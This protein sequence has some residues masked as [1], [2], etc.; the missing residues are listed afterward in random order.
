MNPA[1]TT[2]LTEM[3]RLYGVHQE[4]VQACNDKESSKAWLNY[5]HYVPAVLQGAWN[6]PD[7]SALQ[8]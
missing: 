6:D 5:F 1:L 2:N 7:E 8:T 3:N 4:A